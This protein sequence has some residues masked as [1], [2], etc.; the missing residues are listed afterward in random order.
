MERTYYV[1]ITGSKSGVLYTGFT[2]NLPQ[3]IYA[4]KAKFVDGFSKKYNVNRL[5]WYEQHQDRDAALLREKR[6]KRW[7]RV[8][9]EELINK[10]NPTWC[11]LWCDIAV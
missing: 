3:R 8:W 5:L 2:S 1:Y 9:K 6:I 7:K 4:H 10:S 11:D